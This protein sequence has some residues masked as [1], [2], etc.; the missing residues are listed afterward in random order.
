MWKRVIIRFEYKLIIDIFSS[1]CNYIVEFRDNSGFLS[2]GGLPD[3]KTVFLSHEGIRSVRTFIK[4]KYV[5]SG[6]ENMHLKIVGRQ[7]KTYSM[8]EGK[9]F[10]FNNNI[11]FIYN[12]VYIRV[13]C[14][15]WNVIM[16]YVE[17]VSD[18]ETIIH[19]SF[20][21]FRYLEKIN[22]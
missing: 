13:Y 10:V 20:S 22:K 9:K 5:I 17:N 18:W 8:I 12:S 14:N 19:K 4:N 3:R 7:K 2:V 15:V 6:T 21:P 16:K 1:W 11:M